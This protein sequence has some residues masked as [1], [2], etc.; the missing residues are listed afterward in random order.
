MRILLIACF[1]LAA[2]SSA[3]AAEWRLTRIDAPARV[4]GIERVD[5]QVR[6][7][8]GGLWYVVTRRENGK[9]AVSF[10]DDM[11]WPK[12][13]DGALPD[14][15]P[16]VGRHDIARAWLAQPTDRYD[17]GVLGDKI[18][19]A[20]LDIETRDGKRETVHLKS[21]AVFEDLQPRIA[22]LDGDGHDEIVVVKS[23]L[24]RGSALAIIGLRRGKYEILAETPPLGGPHRWLNPA[25]IGDFTG[26]GK[27]D[28]AL[29]R[30]PHVVGAL[31]I[32]NWHDGRLQ[33][34]A[35]MKDVSNHIAGTRALDMSVVAD[36][37]GD[38]IADIAIPSLDR[39]RL[40]VLSFAPRPREIANIAL[41]AKAVTN[42]GLIK[43]ESGP[44]V[45]LALANGSLVLIERAP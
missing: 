36:F 1:V 28:I 8:I 21:D 32:W 41:P 15:K 6:A 3:H 35:E 38:G 7:Y 17:H 22:D 14:S 20:A 9:V 44:A 31:E 26:N 43:G 30:Q 5:G 42:L 33:K 13:P 10:R 34:V 40:R 39:S 24:K 18:E 16:A 12:V 11:P 27:I 45:A 4:S 25:G 19:A 23:Y 29:V 37:D 2:A